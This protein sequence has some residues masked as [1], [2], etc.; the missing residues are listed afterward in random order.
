LFK[1]KSKKNLKTI[2]LEVFSQVRTQNGQPLFADQSSSWMIGDLV[3]FKKNP[4]PTK[5]T[6]SA[7]F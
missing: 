1:L 7:A 6:P 3:F 5:N 2:S 4:M